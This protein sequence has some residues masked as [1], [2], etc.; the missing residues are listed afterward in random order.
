MTRSRSNVLQSARDILRTA[1]LGLRD[2]QSG[3]ADRRLAG[4]RNA[5]VFGRAVTNVLENLRSRCA[6]FGSWYKVQSEALATDVDMKFLYKLR[7]EILK[8]DA[9]RCQHARRARA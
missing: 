9:S 7:S 4:L 5:V 1:E 2:L 3:P 6:K 8:R